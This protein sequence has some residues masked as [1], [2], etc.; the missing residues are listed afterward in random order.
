MPLISSRNLNQPPPE[1]ASGAH[2]YHSTV[3]RAIRKPW[4]RKQAN[5]GSLIRGR[6]GGRAVYAL[7]PFDDPRDHPLVIRIM[8]QG[9]RVRRNPQGVGHRIVLYLGVTCVK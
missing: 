1:R 5:G 8:K 6:R 9:R 4:T 2:W 7:D 3:R